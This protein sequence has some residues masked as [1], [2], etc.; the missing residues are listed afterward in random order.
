MPNLQNLKAKQIKLRKV[1]KSKVDTNLKGNKIKRKNELEFLHKSKNK[2]FDTKS[3][4]TNQE[5]MK[6]KKK[7]D[8]D[9][10]NIVDYSIS[11]REEINSPTIEMPKISTSTI[12]KNISNLN[13][14][15]H[16]I[17]R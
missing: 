3:I 13:Y 9:I 16:I 8:K 12:S 5:M 15:S 11:Y 17:T 6:I 7:L 2:V 4:I 10:S 1:P 14:N